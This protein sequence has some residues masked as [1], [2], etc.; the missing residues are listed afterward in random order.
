MSIVEYLNQNSGAFSVILTIGILTA[1]IIYVIVSNRMHKEMV[2]ER[3]DKNR[4]VIAIT[5][6]RITTGFFD[7]VIRNISNIPALNIKFLQFPD[8]NALLKG[9]DMTP[10]FLEHGIQYLP[11]GQEYRSFFLQYV[12]NSEIWKEVLKFELSFENVN[13]KNYNEIVEINL[14]VYLKGGFLGYPHDEQVER[15]LKSIDKSL[16]DLS[17]KVGQLLKIQDSVMKNGHHERN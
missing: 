3:E 9:K 10:G 13:K 5:L 14:S 12:E 11:P 7:I 4:P 16:Q 17:K 6:E 2:N 15:S 8:V 1:T